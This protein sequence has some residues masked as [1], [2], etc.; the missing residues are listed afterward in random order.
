MRAIICFLVPL[1]L[2]L[3]VSPVYGKGNPCTSP[4]IHPEG[5][6][7]DC[8]NQPIYPA[9]Q[10]CTFTCPAGYVQ[11]GGSPD[12]LCRNGKWVSWPVGRDLECE[13]E[14]VDGGWSDW[15]PWSGCS[16]T[17]GIGTETRDRSCTNP[18]PAHGGADCV[19]PDQEAQD[20]DTGVFCPVDGGWSDWGPWSGC[21]VTCGIGTETRDRSCTNPAPAHGGADC[22]G[23]DQ[24]AQDCDT[25]VFCPVDGGWSDWG[26][27]SGC[28][29]TCGIGTETRDRSCTNPAPAHGGA[30]CVGQ[31]QEAQDCDTGVFCPVD[32]GWSDWGPW[33]G[34][35][36]TCGNGTET[37]DRS[38]T[39]PAP[40][41]GGADC[42]G[43]DQE[44][45]DCDTGVFCPVDGGWSDWGPWSGCSVTCGN[46]T[47]TRDRS[48]TNPAPAHGGADC[49]G[50]DQEAQ[51]CDTAVFCPVDGGWSDWG[52]WSGCSV[53]CGIGTET[54]DRSCTNPAPAHGGADCV[55]PDE[56]V[57]DC[58][59]GVP[60]PVDGGW[61][62]WSPWSGCSVTCGIGT[63]T[64]DRSCTNP[65]PAHGGADC[66]GPDEEVQDCDTGVPCPVDGEWSDWSPWSGCSVT[67]GSGTQTRDRSCTNPAPAHG[68][69]DCVGPDEEAQD[70]D[71]G[72][73]CPVDGEW[74]DWSPWSGCS[75]T[76]GSGTE[77]RDRSCTNPAPAHGGTDCVGPD[78][79]VQACDAGV[80]CPAPTTEVMTTVLTTTA[81]TMPTRATTTIPAKAAT[82]MPSTVATTMPTRVATTTQTMAAVCPIA[83]DYVIF[84]GICYKDFDELKTYEEA[85]Q[86][87]AADGGLL[88]MP[89]DSATNAFIHTLGG[90][91]IRWIGL[92]DLINEAFPTVEPCDES[93]D[94]FFVL[95]GSDSVSLADFD[96]VKEFVVAVVSG[97]TISLTDTRVGV[98]QYSDGS[99]LECNLGDHPDWSSFVNSMNT[100]ARQGGGT[101][102]GAALEFARLIAAWR[103]APV[104][105]RIMIVLTDG[106]SEDSVVTPAQALATEQVT[107]F[108]IGVGSFNRS[109]LLQITN[110]NQD[111][112]FEL[113]DFN[114]IANIMNRIIQAA[115]INIVFPTVEPCDVTTDLFFVLD[116][117]GSV[118]LYNF[119]TV[120]QFVVTLVSAF[121]IGLNDVND[122]RVGVLQY[123]SSNTLGC[124]LGDHPD[125]SSFV[126]AMNAMRYHY[127]PSTQTGAALQAAGQI[128][129]WRPAPVPRIMVVVTDGMA[130]DSVVAPSQ[131]LAADQVNVFAIGVGN[132]VRSELLQIANNNQA[133]VFELADF[134]AI[135]DNINDIALAVCMG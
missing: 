98:L 24:E 35:S 66:V 14:P 79:E 29:V 108:A 47:E 33:S 91:E 102:T 71:T 59:T 73:P 30:D 38:C 23:P 124:N 125:L 111:R 51:D 37:R 44:A 61:S 129:A 134:N 11:T 86:T 8:A 88:A 22:V 39:N 70:C 50:P 99:T 106:D 113:A 49:V 3:N 45:Q 96:I 34:C 42:V 12:K 90:N 9:G 46:G 72:V 81:T 53:T 120:K 7:S 83:P 75:V 69:A 21:S 78:E 95:D 82:T 48:C 2:I 119:N 85:R 80:P 133:R 103:P 5:Y 94:L 115:C 52:P 84:N 1:V 27:W 55:G 58:D 104:V 28:S 76:C 131:G 128:A 43:P 97:F 19:G 135:R 74:S 112:V 101:S 26:P 36:V 6:T 92:N 132:Y 64:R 32:G 56:E 107:V 89:R 77:T 40:A 18:A 127:G 122:T 17:C 123:S 10:I 110:N 62:D 67:C 68:G 93:V 114:A 63:E 41:H 60:C 16:V 126:N 13:R 118:G 65:A 4:P 20:C 105:P 87:C 117:S 25:A 109:E 54:R 116:G 100:M 130:H 57:Q 121:T 31:D 15:G